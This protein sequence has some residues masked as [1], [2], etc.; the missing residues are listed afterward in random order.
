MLNRYDYTYEDDMNF[1]NYETLSIPYEPFERQRSPFQPHQSG[2]IRPTGN[3]PPG[4]NYPGGGFNPPGFNSPVGGNTQSGMPKSPPPNYIPNKNDGGVQ[5]FNQGNYGA[6]TKAVSQNSIRFCLYKYTY[7]WEVNGRSYWAFLLNIDRVSVS[8]FRWLGRRWVYFGVDLRRIDSFVCYNRSAL[9]GDCDNCKNLRQD[10]ISLLSSK[11]D[12]SLYGARDVYTQTLASIDIPEIKEDFLDQ[13]IDCVD[14]NLLKSEVPCPC[15]KARNIRYRISLEVTYPSTYDKVLK[16]KINE[17]AN[18][19][20]N[21]AYK[22]L[23]STRNT[24]GYSNPLET[25][26]LSVS[27][28]PEALTTFSDS[29]N[30]KVKLISSD[31]DINKDIAY[32][33]RE[34]KDH[35]NWKPYL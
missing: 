27:L 7:I 3:F 31:A 35:E 13:T 14:S 1:Q 8:G 26:N 16:N 19:A 30:S 17:L 24:D 29:F 15:I 32:S 10:D 33:I 20:S 5:S 4:F 28:I 21:D 2:N 18:E 25:F 23:S 11:K 12:Y 22:I 6:G 9:V 34:E